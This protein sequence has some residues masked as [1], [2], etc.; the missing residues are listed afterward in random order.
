MDLATSNVTEPANPSGVDGQS[1]GSEAAG[2]A[3]AVIDDAPQGSESAACASADGF[4]HETETDQ[5]PQRLGLDASGPE[6]QTHRTSQNL[7]AVRQASTVLVRGAQEVSQ[8]M[9]GLVQ[10]QLTKRVDGLNRI[11]GCRS[12]RAFVAAQSELMRDNLALV[13]DTN[14]RI[15]A[16]SVRIADEAAEAIQSQADDH[17][18]H[19][20]RAV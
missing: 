8:E 14:R 3:R 12:V 18:A 7:R 9:F 17:P 4:E 16:L 15:A 13:I 6:E 5:V 20:H 2:L 11:A 10:E 1:P 19:V